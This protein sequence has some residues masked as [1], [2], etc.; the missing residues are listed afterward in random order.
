MKVLVLT[1]SRAAMPMIHGL[2]QSGRLAGIVVSA[3]SPEDTHDMAAWA[4]TCN[5]P[6]ISVL[7]G[8]LESKLGEALARLAPDLV[9]VYTF[10]CKIPA[11]LLSLQ[12]HFYNVHFSLLPAYRG[13][14]PV[15]WQI[16]NGEPVTGVTVHRMNER[17]D[18]GTIIRQVELPLI[19]GE[20]AGILS[21][22]LDQVAQGILKELL[23]NESYKEEG[24]WREQDEENASYYPRPG[25]AQL[26][27]DW[28]G[29][30]AQEIENLV[31]ACNPVYQGALT[32]LRG[33]AVRIAE[34]A[35][36]DMNVPEVYPPGTIVY[37]DQPYGVFVLCKD[38]KVLRINIIH[39]QEGTVTGFKL[40]AMGVT[41]GERFGD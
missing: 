16:R 7:P 35:P 5:V 22:R 18:A 19:P 31:N 20:T 9:W 30:T 3:N 25:A 34:V 14:S 13:P 37:A 23:T 12:P 26:S 21:A 41:A 11:A 10:S 28:N 33:Q 40:A 27:I 1:G 17:Y 39:M 6:Y 2:H 29:S 24:S 8:T 32:K 15:F 38:G 4:G 36:A